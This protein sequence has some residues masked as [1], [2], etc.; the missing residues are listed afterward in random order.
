[1]LLNKRQKN[2]RFFSYNFFSKN[3]KAVSGIVVMVIMI[4]LVMAVAAVV[5]T[6]TKKTVEK[7]IKKS[8]ACGPNIIGQISINSEYVCYD[9]ENQEIRFSINRG[10]VDL[11][12]LI[13]AVETESEAIQFELTSELKNFSNL[14]PFNKQLG[15]AV[16]LP[17]KNGGKTY[18]GTGF[19]EDIIGIKI[20]PVINGEQCEIADSLTE[21]TSC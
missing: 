6:T 21:I 16:N 1:M 2:Q 18:I 3:R 19:N 17:G 20:A 11:D 14:Y 9:S 4:A 13:V 5:F 15:D 12:K 8:E 10:N 7:Q